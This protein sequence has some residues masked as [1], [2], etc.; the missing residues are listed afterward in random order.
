M[1]EITSDSDYSVI[2]GSEVK[3]KLSLDSELNV[4]KADANGKDVFAVATLKAPFYETSESSR[5]AIDLCVV[6]D[7]S[8]SM[9]GS[10][11]E[12]CKATL[13]FIIEQ[14]SSRDSLA[15]VIYGSTVKTVFDFTV[16]DTE[17]K[18]KAQEKVKSIDTSGCTNL[19]GGLFAGMDLI[20]NRPDEKK[21]E[22]QSLLLLTDGMANEGIQD[23]QA[24]IAAMRDPSKRGKCMS[25]EAEKEYKSS[26]SYNN[27]F[28]PALANIGNIGNNIG[29]IGIVQQQCSNVND[30]AICQ[31]IENEFEEIQAEEAMEE[32]ENE[33][34][35]QQIQ[36]Q[37]QA[38]SF[39]IPSFRPEVKHMDI[40][41][42]KGVGIDA[43]NMTVYTFGYGS[44]HDANL[45]K[46]I[47]D[48]G[49]GAYY[50]IENKDT[51]P[52]AFANCLGGLLS[53]VAQRVTLKLEIA[54]GNA[55]PAKITKLHT[56]F[57]YESAGEDGQKF[58]VS[59]GD[60]QSEEERNVAFELSFSPM[61]HPVE[62][63]TPCVCAQVT[64]ANEITNNRNDSECAVLNICRPSDEKPQEITDDVRAKLITQKNRI[65][66]AEAL[67]TA[68][69]SS[70]KGDYQK[71]RDCL[72]DAIQNITLS[73]DNYRKKKS[74]SK[75]KTS[76]AD[77]EFF[78]TTS[79][80]LNDL[81]DA[82]KGMVDAK[83]VYETS[84]MTQ[85]YWNE[86]STAVDT[87]GSFQTSSR[88]KMMAKSSKSAAFAFSKG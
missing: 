77:D 55:M 34:D 62:N 32:D 76:K 53:V 7:R 52:L 28:M 15:V 60:I 16:M 79:S 25:D 84:R 59:L 44:S 22:V 11:L 58:I 35:Q 71:G 74:K 69:K 24:I 14:M 17:G 10:P 83:G 2:D 68:M 61:A 81:Q 46:A 86:R 31:G 1:S 80:L 87:E 8:G 73:S 30:M 5:P 19:S 4:I 42:T 82:K 65:L 56:R 18:D 39:S 38:F 29:D 78:S 20:T 49:R 26:D 13:E 45:M 9:S 40:D 12:L 64:Y 66:A 88:K 48:A 37:Q 36:Q 6:I 47:S 23:P 54:P 57:P 67:E 72:S 51:I 50:F 63:F 41:L 43:S 21:N 75:E 70:E 33:N 3:L 27:A 85:M